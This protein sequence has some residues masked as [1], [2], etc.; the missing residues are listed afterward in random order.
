M[1]RAAVES[2]NAQGDDWTVDH[3]NRNAVLGDGPKQSG[4]R[5]HELAVATGL[6][7]ALE[8]VAGDL[9]NQYS[10]VYADTGDAKASRKL[11]VSV[12][13]RGV[14]VRAPSKIGG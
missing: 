8:E 7:S 4:G 1:D 9:L 10:I 11:S 14:I 6:T 2:G 3:A 5:R 12:K 13:R